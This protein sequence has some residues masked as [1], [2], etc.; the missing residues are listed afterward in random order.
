MAIRVDSAGLELASI[1][2]ESHHTVAL[3]EVMVTGATATT[4]LRAQTIRNRAIDP[5]P[6]GTANA[7]TVHTNAFAARTGALWIARALATTH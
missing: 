1:A 6:I 3:A 7:S 2:D 4:I 5:S